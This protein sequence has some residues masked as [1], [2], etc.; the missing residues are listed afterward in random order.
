MTERWLTI[1]GIGEDGMAGLSPSAQRA[2]ENAEVIIGGDRH[3]ALSDNVKAQRLRWPHPFDALIDEL[4][5]LKPRRPVVLATGDP[6]WYSV[7]ARIGKAISPEEITYFPQLS[8]FQWAAA[9]MGWSLADVETLTAHGRPAAQITPF[10]WPNAR[11]LVLT[12]GAQTPEE[13]AT[14]L[15]DRG[16]GG[17]ELTVLGNLG[18]PN[19]TQLSGT[20]SDWAAS[21]PTDK[22]PPFN[23]LA[24]TC[25]GKPGRLLP[26]TPGLPD[27]AFEH[28][29]QLTKREVRSL[30]LARLMP[31][32]GA[33]LWDIGTGCGSVAIEWM[34][35]ARDAEAIGID[36]HSG[37]L[38]MAAR[39]AQTLGT[40]RLAL[41]EGEA[42]DHLADLPTPDAIFIGGGLSED[43][44]QRAINALSANGRLVANAVTLES[45]AILT[46][47]HRTHG[48]DLT[49][50]LVQRAERVGAKTGWRPAMPVTQWALIK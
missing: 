27:D 34:R 1:V 8:A 36:R 17:S 45:E 4:R 10:F 15:T 14:L 7:G 49:R 3:H 6:L 23:T 9:R 44:A 41:I 24:I 5:A 47:L 31:T 30:T 43:L 20:A 19:E 18:A 40:P 29:G 33:Q 35:G 50:L 11:L 46:G 21:D 25:R 16:Y 37:R 2:V 12:S 48:G 26:R 32:R 13:I 28:D 39:N 38:A 22:V 42:S